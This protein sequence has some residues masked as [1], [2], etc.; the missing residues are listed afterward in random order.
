M[1]NPHRGEVVLRVGSGSGMTEYTIKLGH[2]AFAC[3]EGE[4]GATPAQLELMLKEPTITL[5]RAILW[6]GLRK[7][8]P[9][10]N[11]EMAGEII[12]EVGA[13]AVADVIGRALSS[14]ALVK[15]AKKTANPRKPNGRSTTG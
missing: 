12:D 15:G 10:I 8:H 14:S 9:E 2:N 13:E 5:V 11:I 4:L 3:L 1:A 6:A 7:H